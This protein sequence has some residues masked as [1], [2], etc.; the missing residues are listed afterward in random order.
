MTL[1]DDSILSAYLDGELGLE[2]QQAVESAACADPQLA[3][4]LRSLAALR[5][6]V[7]GLPAEASPDVADRVMRRI[8]RRTSRPDTAA[9]IEWGPIR[10]AVLL[11]LAASVLGILA[12]S[13]SLPKAGAPAPVPL[14]VWQAPPEVKARPIVSE[15]LWPPGTGERNASRADRPGAK[16]S[17]PSELVHVREYLDNPQLRRIFLVADLEDGSAQRQVASFV[18]QTTRFNFYK[19]TI[20]QGIVIDPR[21]PDRATVF[22]LAVGPREL[23]SLRERLR[24]ALKDRVEETD[25]QPA[26][27]TQLADIGDVEACPPVPAAEMAIP[28]DQ[29]FA[30]RGAAEAAPAGDAAEAGPA[31]HPKPPDR[32]TLE[33]ERS[34]PNADVVAGARAAGPHA[35]PDRRPPNG[36]DPDEPA[37]RSYVLVWVFRPRP[38]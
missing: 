12:L 18:E 20:S 29:A 8:R 9:S 17:T 16:P 33:Q 37:D 5:E 35:E 23:E 3:E 10:S 19:I 32:A 21:H 7:A 25:V 28:R 30:L 31:E 38:A 2:Q 26:V 13:W 27:V 34:R 4:E 1:D 11:G 24:T 36:P 6:L 15:R 14:V 22:A